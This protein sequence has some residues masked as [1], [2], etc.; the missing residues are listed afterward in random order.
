MTISIEKPSPAISVVVTTYNIERYISH[1]ITS[2]QGQTFT[3]FELIF[4][5]DG[6]T[7][8]TM[9]VAERNLRFSNIPRK[10]I[11]MPENTPGGVATAGNIG[12]LASEGKYICYV[13]G[14][15]WCEPDML[16]S[17][18][19]AAEAS[20]ADIVLADFR[21]Y[22]ELNAKSIVP[23]D[24]PR[25][26]ALKADIDAGKPL[27]ELRKDVLK[28]NAVPWRKFYRRSFLTD[29]QIEFPEGN[30]FFEDN[31]YHWFCTTQATSIAAIDQ[32]ICHHR[33]NRPGQTVAS[34]G[35]ELLAFY[36][37]F[38]TILDFLREKQIL[39]KYQDI[40]IG[41]IVGQTEFVLQKINTRLFPDVFLCLQ[42]A[43]RPWGQDEI[44]RALYEKGTGRS[45]W[46]MVNLVIKGDLLEFCYSKR[47]GVP[48]EI[49]SSADLQKSQDKISESLKTLTKA[50]QDLKASL[51]ENRKAEEKKLA[52]RV[53]DERK[54]H[55]SK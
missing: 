47:F 2:I 28:L 7:D 19:A 15:D 17:F 26:K 5:D 25:I 39:E 31:P 30:F 11:A 34:A 32:V 46:Q 53:Y 54:G 51:A 10:I 38:A 23:N 16:A 55:V 21:N 18:Y 6:S 41:W 33:I 36:E 9:A 27:E 40:L 13:D 37:H 22:D 43:L 45:G 44:V 12:V 4:V 8:E 52:Y 29:N 50:H 24:S 35:K 20:N 48:S 1:C 42:K 14:D 3:D 49:H